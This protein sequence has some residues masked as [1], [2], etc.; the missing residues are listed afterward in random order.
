MLRR[1]TDAA[2]NQLAKERA[3]QTSNLRPAG[4]NLWL[5]NGTVAARSHPARAADGCCHNEPCSDR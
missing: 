4:K 1:G 2:D 5:S 3:S